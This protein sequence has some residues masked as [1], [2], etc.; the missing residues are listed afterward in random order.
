MAA[1]D[2]SEGWEEYSRRDG[3]DEDGRECGNPVLP[4]NVAHGIFD[5]LDK[6]N[7]I[8]LSTEAQHAVVRGFTQ[9]LKV[10]HVDDALSHSKTESQDNKRARSD[11][12]QEKVTVLMMQVSRH[13]TDPY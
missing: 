9:V 8:K 12:Q 3:E 10:F 2:S 1:A 13:T 5:Q 6:T 7:D 4:Y 11:R